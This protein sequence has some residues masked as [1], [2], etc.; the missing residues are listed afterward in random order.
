MSQTRSRFTDGTHNF[1]SEKYHAAFQSS[2]WA[3]CPIKEIQAD[4]SLG[5]I[6][7]EHWTNFVGSISGTTLTGWTGQ[8]QT[9]GSGTLPD[10]LGG[11]LRL[12]AAATTAA[13][14]V[15]FQKLG[16]VF[17]PTVSKPI[18]FEAKVI[19]NTTLAA[20]LFVGLA[21]DDN[22]IISGSANTSTDHIGWQS[23][24]DD[25]VLLFTA[26]KAGA[27]VTKASTTLV[28]GTA[29]RLGFRV[30]NATATTMK[31]EHWVND[32]KQSTTQLNA[33]VTVEAIKPSLVCQAGGT[34]TP[35][36]DNVYMKCVQLY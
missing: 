20:E 19:L 14:G 32:T 31:I 12:N 9:S 34:G 6:F 25:G 16:E 21:K 23:V 36:F 22:T 7:E 5:F 29:V 15:Q 28:A 13:R 35:T 10:G 33:N 4:P 11:L 26:E 30:L 17:L 1:Y 3:N 8:N 2:V 24:T 27:G 18:W